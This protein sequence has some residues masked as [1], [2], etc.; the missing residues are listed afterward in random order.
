MWRSAVVR[1]LSCLMA[2]PAKPI[3]TCH[4]VGRFIMVVVLMISLSTGVILDRY[5]FMTALTT[6]GVIFA[7]MAGYPLGT[8]QY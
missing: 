3:Q 2:R 8:G 6:F 4:L 5:E 1:G 7:S